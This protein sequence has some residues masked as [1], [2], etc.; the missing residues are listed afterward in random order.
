MFHKTLKIKEFLKANY[1]SALVDSSDKIL[2]EYIEDIKEKLEA[3]SNE[4]GDVMAKKSVDTLIKKLNIEIENLELAM[5]QY[6]NG[7]LLLQTSNDKKIPWNGKESYDFLKEGL[8]FSD[9]KKKLL[10]NL[11]KCCNYLNSLKTED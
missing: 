5:R 8:A 6:D 3:M 9:H 2:D 10:I 11:N 1:N 4:Q 7:L